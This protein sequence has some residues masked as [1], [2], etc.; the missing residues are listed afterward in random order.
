MGAFPL[1]FPGNTW[2]LFIP[3]FL[4]VDQNR[5]CDG[6]VHHRL[7]EDGIKAL[8]RDCHKLHSKL[9]LWSTGRMEVLL[10]RLHEF[11]FCLDLSIL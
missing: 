2:L 5:A 3:F 11:A 10:P 1:S 6:F 4:T 7:Q 8:D 9:T